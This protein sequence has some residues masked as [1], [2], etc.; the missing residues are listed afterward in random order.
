MKSIVRFFNPRTTNRYYLPATCLVRLAVYDVTGNLV[1]ILVNKIQ[2]KGRHVAEWD[3]SDRNG[4]PFASGL[5]ICTVT[6]DNQT[7][8]RKLVLLR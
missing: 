4:T 2:E 1:D 8:S 3:G 7:I 5:Y 6:A